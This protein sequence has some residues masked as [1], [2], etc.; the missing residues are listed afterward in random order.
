ME[1]KQRIEKKGNN[2]RRMVCHMIDMITHMKYG[3]D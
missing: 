2:E 3:G 1:E